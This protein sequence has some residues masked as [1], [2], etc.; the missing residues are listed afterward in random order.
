MTRLPKS[1]WIKTLVTVFAIAV[2]A[3]ILPLAQ[4]YIAKGPMPYSNAAA[5]AKIKAR[6]VSGEYFAFIA[7]GDPHAGLFLNDSASLKIINRINRED[8]FKKIPI[9]FVAM[10]GDIS[11][12]GSGWD[13]LVFNKLRSLIKWPVVSVMGNHDNDKA[14]EAFFKRYIGEAQYSFADRNS[15]FIVL[16]NEAGD[17]NEAQFKWFE[18]ELKK[19]LVFKHRFV[20]M[21]KAPLSPYQQSWFRPELNP[22][23]YRFMKLCEAYK[24]GIVFSG[25]E[26]MFHEAAYGGVRYITSGGGGNI[27]HFPSSD[28]GFLHYVVV[29]VYGDYV[30]YEVRK[31]FPPLWEYFTYYLWK[32][33]FYT[34]VDIIY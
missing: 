10:I 34:L 26:H 33:V 2:I 6:G 12:R 31:V 29:R 5:C 22:W 3:S 20:F 25:H 15:F 13:Y 30:D 27:I 8:R 9:D 14:G 24:V 21:H 23:A 11:F 17:L 1:I 32:D 19:A 28:G 18:A 16:N 7:L 4:L